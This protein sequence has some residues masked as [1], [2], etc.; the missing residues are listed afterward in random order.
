MVVKDGKAQYRQI[1][2]GRDFGDSVEVRLGLSGGDHVA[3][4]PNDELVDGEPVQERPYV[5]DNPI[6]SP[7]AEPAAKT[8]AIESKP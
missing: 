4:S 2:I 8:K 6:L 7:L 3:V 1:T 5:D